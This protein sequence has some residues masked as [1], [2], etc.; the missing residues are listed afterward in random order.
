MA[1]LSVGEIADGASN[2]NDDDDDNDNEGAGAGRLLRCNEFLVRMNGSE[3]VIQ[4]LQRAEFLST[5]G[6]IWH[7][8]T[9]DYAKTS[10][11]KK[12]NT[13]ELI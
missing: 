3:V 1:K 2:Y 4:G 5:F 8:F 7:E 11:A 6:T 10:G 13:Q 12:S 9:H